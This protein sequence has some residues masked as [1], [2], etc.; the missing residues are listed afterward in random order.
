MKI[1]QSNVSLTSSNRYYEENS[2]SVKSGMSM[3]SSFIDSLKEQEKKAD[4]MARFEVSAGNAALTSENY[5]SLK[6]EKTEYLSPGTDSLEEQ[7]SQIRI[8]ILERILSLL[9]LLGGERG[10][11]SYY[12]AL[13]DTSSMLSSNVFIQTTTITATHIEEE[14]T[15]FCGKGTAVTEDGREIDFNVEFSMSRRLVESAGMSTSSAVSFIDPLVINVGNDVTHVSDQ[16]FYFDLDCDGTNEKI[17]NLGAGSGFIAY[18]KNGDGIINNGSELFGTKSGNGFKD[19]QVYDDN[20]DGWIDESDEIYDKLQ[21][22]TR[23]ADGTDTLLKLK[24]ADVGAIYLGSTETQF[25]HF[26]SAFMQTAQTRASGLFLKESGGIGLVQ[27]LDLA[28]LA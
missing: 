11:G 5:T 26:G 13:S 28:N 16:S 4:Q 24:E 25:S 6:P 9:R 2:I 15:T 7:L 1:T 21:I 23:S 20:N 22:W 14:S 3:R 8:S 17:S 12:K 10:S 27:Q 18:D 19:L